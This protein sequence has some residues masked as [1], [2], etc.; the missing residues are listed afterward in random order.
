MK[1]N[2]RSL[3]RYMIVFG[4]VILAVLAFA[5]SAWAMTDAQSVAPTASVGNACAVD[6]ANPPDCTAIDSAQPTP[7][8][9][10]FKPAIKTDSLIDAPMPGKAEHYPF[11][12][13]C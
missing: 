7:P 6:T 4:A 11:S 1:T 8:V 10:G 13:V 5:A 2:T 3:V 9:E 12:W